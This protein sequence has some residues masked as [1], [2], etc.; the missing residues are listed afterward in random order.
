MWAS[1]KHVFEERECS[2]HV[3]FTETKQPIS[4]QSKDW[5]D[6]G[7]SWFR[8]RLPRPYIKLNHTSSRYSHRLCILAHT[9]IQY[10]EAN[11]DDAANMQRCRGAYGIAAI[12]R[13]I[14][15]IVAKL[16]NG[17]GI[18]M[19]TSWSWNYRLRRV[20]FGES[21]CRKWRNF[22]CFFVKIF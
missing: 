17:R 5:H 21:F 6:T 12:S 2:Q 16:M 11:L 22:S 19:C 4:S 18:S 10:F 13:G 8:E 14:F 1:V 7:I 3:Q 9:I 20:K 15:Q